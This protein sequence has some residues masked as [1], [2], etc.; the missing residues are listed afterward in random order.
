MIFV[1]SS[2]RCV[3]AYA[4]L[5]PSSAMTF[6]SLP[7]RSYSFCVYSAVRKLMSG[8]LVLF[9]YQSLKPC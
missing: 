6:I 3:A 9:L 5:F 1:L 7:S 4:K 8:F 2:L